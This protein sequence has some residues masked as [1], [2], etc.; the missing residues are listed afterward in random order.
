VDDLFG[1]ARN[2]I[3]EIGQLTNRVGL[4]FA[5]VPDG[6]VSVGIAIAFG[7]TDFVL[8]SIMGGDESQVSLS[9]GVRRDVKQD[10][11]AAL[12]LCNY[13]TR[14]RPAYPIYLHEAPIGWD[15]LLST[16]FP[17]QVLLNSPAFYKALVLGLPEVVE[18][19]R[20]TADEDGLGGEPYRWNAEDLHRLLICTSV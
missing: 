16:G 3:K 12:T 20:T 2:A 4:Q 1:D 15:I 8:A 10:Q 11:L 6:V 13:L 7:E 14:N 9:C 18:E 5:D 19:A 17:L